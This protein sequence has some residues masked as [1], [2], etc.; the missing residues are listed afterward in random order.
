MSEQVRVLDHGYVRLVE[1]WGSDERIIEAAR[2]STAKGFE[3]WGRSVC[4]R[5]GWKGEPEDFSVS[6]PGCSHE[7]KPEHKS[8]ARGARE[9]EAPGSFLEERDLEKRFSSD[10]AERGH[11]ARASRAECPEQINLNFLDQC[12]G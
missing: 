5:C 12:G 4:V 8:A 6:C 9:V 11:L 2:M 1:T 10:L 3:G 7:E